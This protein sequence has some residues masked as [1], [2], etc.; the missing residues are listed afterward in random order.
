MRSFDEHLR[1]F[2]KERGL[3]PRG[4]RGISEKFEARMKEGMASN[5]SSASRKEPTFLSRVSQTCRGLKS[6]LRRADCASFYDTTGTA[7]P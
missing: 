6:C 4:L 1:R 3:K 2:R 5:A 7:S